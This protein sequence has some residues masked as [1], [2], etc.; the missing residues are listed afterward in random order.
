M[1]D[2]CSNSTFVEPHNDLVCDRHGWIIPQHILFQ[3]GNLFILFSFFTPKTL[4]GHMVHKAFISAGFF[5]LTIWVWIIKCIPDA[6]AWN[7]LFAVQALV[8][9]HIDLWKMRTFYFN[10]EE[11]MVFR[12]VFKHCGATRYDFHRLLKA[13]KWSTLSQGLIETRD[14]PTTRLRLVITGLVHISRN[15]Q[16]LLTVQGLEFIESMDVYEPTLDE[17]TIAEE[18]RVLTWKKKQL[19][20][21]MQDSHMQAV[22]DQVLGRDISL[23]FNRALQMHPVA[24]QTMYPVEAAAASSAP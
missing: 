22:M 11:E 21:L 5:A 15:Q 16:L 13:G 10:P 6:V 4:L 24:A 17:V 7:L 12:K 2:T 14:K 8:S 9:V 20:E 23:K 1:A 18:T 3:F 19:T